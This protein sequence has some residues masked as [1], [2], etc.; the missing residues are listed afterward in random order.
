MAEE[1]EKLRK[2]LAQEKKIQERI[3]QTLGN[4]IETQGKEIERLQHEVGKLVEVFTK[5]NT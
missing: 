4:L 5:E 1:I 2:E 3:N